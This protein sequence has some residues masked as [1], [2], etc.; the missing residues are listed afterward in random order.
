[1]IPGRIRDSNTRNDTLCLQWRY[2]ACSK[3]ISCKWHLPPCN[4]GGIQTVAL[5]SS[6]TLCLW[7]GPMQEDPLSLLNPLKT[8]QAQANQAHKI[9]TAPPIATAFL[10][11]P[12]RA[13]TL[14]PGQQVQN[15]IGNA[16]THACSY[17]LSSLPASWAREKHIQNA[18][19]T[20]RVLPGQ[21]ASLIA[22]LGGTGRT[23]LLAIA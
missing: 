3:L 9:H 18:A 17:T 16:A 6:P 22:L 15:F 5:T 2:S 19:G 23:S 14:T 13:W 7:V 11:C 8:S 10:W 1:M 20:P 4:H 21:P 12:G